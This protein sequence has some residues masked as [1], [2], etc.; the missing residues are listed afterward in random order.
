[1]V[2][3]SKLVVYSVLIMVVFSLGPEVVVDSVVV[4]DSDSVTVWW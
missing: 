4:I 3:D 1:M 2:V